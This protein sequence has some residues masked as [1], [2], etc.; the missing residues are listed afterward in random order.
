MSDTIDLT[1][2]QNCEDQVPFEQIENPNPLSPEI[3]HYQGTINIGTIG[4]VAHGKT[5]LVKAISSK[6]TIRHNEEYERN[7]TIKLGYANAKIWKCE[8]E[9][10]PKYN[11]AETYLS[12]NSE[13]MLSPQ[14]K[15][16]NGDMSLLRHVSFVDTPG[17][18]YL[19]SVMLGGA[20]VME[21]AILLI[22]A[23]EPCPQPQTRE[24]L[25]AV[26]VLGLENVIACQNKCDLV[27][28]D[29]ANAQ[30]HDIR[31]YL[32]TTSTAQNAPIIP[33]SAQ[34]NIN[35]DLVLQKL[36]K[37]IPIPSSES[38]E[39]E[40]HMQ[41][42][43]SFDVNMPGNFIGDLVGGVIGGTLLQG[44]LKL[45]EEIEIRPG[46]LHETEEGW[47]YKPIITRI[48][49][50]KSEHTSL[51]FAVP[52]GL[53]AVQTEVDPQTTAQDNLMGQIAGHPNTLDPVVIEIDVNFTL[54]TV[55][56]GITMA[57]GSQVKIKS[58][59]PGESLMIAIGSKTC[60]GEII[61]TRNPNCKIRLKQPV[62]T[63]IGRKVALSRQIA[64]HWRLI[65]WG[66]ISAVGEIE[67]FE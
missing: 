24:H 20:S 38:F 5:T 58:L 64:K 48:V 45:R 18:E 44:V 27:K 34:F 21:G 63:N 19:M 26:G 53:I 46:I 12:T 65:G 17:H 43:R 8:N 25:A 22:A 56:L 30:M 31:R 54:L 33:I 42:V 59:R 9:T 36:V 29:A 60:E 41:I 37:T 3:M 51:S 40:P 15:F 49:A 55:L 67:Q 11:E 57:S 52:G 4:H 2:V 23:N 62:C 35:V 32:C 16:C 50:L 13:K 14:C 47:K 1:E 10:C 7:I 39:K 28:R 61:E 6:F 66:T